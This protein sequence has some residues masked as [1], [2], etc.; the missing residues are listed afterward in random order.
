M[1]LLLSLALALTA[2]HATDQEWSRL[3]QMTRKAQQIA[4]RP[5]V[6]D[7][8]IASLLT[9][10]IAAHERFLSDNPHHA[11]AWAAL[12]RLHWDA[13]AHE[14]ADQAFAAGW[15]AD[16][17]QTGVAVSW[18]SAWLQRDPARGIAV[19][20]ACLEE[21]PGDVVLHVNRLNALAEHAPSGIDPRFEALLEQSDDSLQGPA[22]M[23]QAMGSGDPQRRERHLR[24]LVAKGPQ[25]PHVILLQ[26]QIARRANQFGRARQLM[27]RLPTAFR[28]N[29]DRRYLYSDTCYGEHDFSDASEEMHA[30]DPASIVDSRPGLH[31][32]LLYLR[33]L[34]KQ[35]DH[36][37][38][39]EQARR[40]A[41]ATQEANPL[42]VLVIDGQEVWCELFPEQA[43][44]SVAAFLELA[45]RGFHD[46]RKVANVH[47]GFRSIFG[48]SDR[49]GAQSNWTLPSEFDPD[50]DRDHFSG[51]LCLLRDPA[52][53]DSAKG[54]FYILHFPAPHLRGVRCSFGR[55]ISGLD[56]IRD[57]DG[58]ETLESIRIVRQGSDLPPAMVLT[59]DGSLAELRSVLP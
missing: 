18:A 50:T 11:S 35:L 42:I 56:V 47:S 49:V 5:E 39:G 52:R 19:L 43:P 25:D 16:P 32:R 46:G 58:T 3:Q 30:I 22:A 28:N 29:P 10:L 36:H 21:R 41:H 14:A 9:N 2:L 51:S 26:A 34:R 38:P 15:A 24:S 23:L 55:V 8:Q 1:H 48:P 12:G 53:E 44:N 59:Q 17:E 54:H 40:L 4:T 6:T 31:R 45:Q 57:M 13:G 20:D 37:W 7:D 27:E 33:P